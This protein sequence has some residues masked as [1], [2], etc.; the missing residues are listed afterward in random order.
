MTSHNE[1]NG[2]V[3]GNVVQGHNVVL[4]DL[5]TRTSSIALYY[6][7]IHIRDDTWLKY[8]SL[9]WPAITR[10]VPAGFQTADSPVAAA[11]V[12]AGVLTD[13]EPHHT[14][15][16]HRRFFAMVESR[17]EELRDRFGIEHRDQ[18]PLQNG[19]P[20]AGRSSDAR[21]TYLHYEK[22]STPVIS[23]IVDSGLG[24]RHKSENGSWVGMHPQLANVYMCHL[25]NHLAHRESLHPVTD[26]EQ[27]H[28]AM[29]EWD[30]DRIADALLGT[31][32]RPERRDAT[33]RF[34]T[35]AVRTVVPE[36]LADVPVE[37]LLELRETF[38]SDFRRFR[39]HVGHRFTELRAEA[40]A[41][42][43]IS[44]ALNELVRSE[45]ADLEDKLRSVKLMPRRVRVQLKADAVRESP[46]GWLFR[47]GQLLR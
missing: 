5:R 39:A 38:F 35:A 29:L 44:V 28:N 36:G 23:A 25:V 20:A 21:L 16:R 11:F 26:Q 4:N 14:A 18:W 27:P 46:V 47:A 8:A 24:L 3:L 10:V 37:Q 41:D 6:P 19:T 22:L 42:L 31:P 1:I 30:I 15:H 2:T 43:H 33:H 13:L 12:R 9:Y 40:T 7:Y 34:M 17:A 32:P 45:L